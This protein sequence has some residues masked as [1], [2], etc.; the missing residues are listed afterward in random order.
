M[1]DR[2]GAGSEDEGGGLSAFEG[3]DNSHSG[4]DVDPDDDGGGDNTDVGDDSLS[5]PS[6]GHSLR[7]PTSDDSSD[8][9]RSS[10]P[11][12]DGATESSD[13]GGGGD[14]DDEMTSAFLDRLR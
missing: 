1:D 9:R 5:Q 7:S 2:L 3:F 13:D 11:E 8:D 14:D 12:S 6:T 4:G 10:R